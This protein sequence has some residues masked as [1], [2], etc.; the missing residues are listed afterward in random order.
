MDKSYHYIITMMNYI[1]RGGMAT[2]FVNV[3]NKP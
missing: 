1:I 3:E 2:L